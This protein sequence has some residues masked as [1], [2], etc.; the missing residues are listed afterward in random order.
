MAPRKQIHTERHRRF[1]ALLVAERK[2]LGITQIEL[3]ERLGKPPSYIA[4][5]EL[6]ERRLD[7]LEL[8]DL[9]TVAGFDPAAF[10]QKLQ[11]ETPPPAENGKSPTQPAKRREE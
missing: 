2:A 3:A 10:V 9:A 5:I 7:V 8:I 11:Q 4:K 1:R 6:G